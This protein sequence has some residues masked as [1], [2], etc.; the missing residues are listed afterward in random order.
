MVL[1]YVAVAGQAQL[2][3]MMTKETHIRPLA[4]SCAVWAGGGFLSASQTIGIP[5]RQGLF[6]MSRR[7]FGLMREARIIDGTP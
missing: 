1:A 7:N 6:F 2:N 5:K 4:P 3:T